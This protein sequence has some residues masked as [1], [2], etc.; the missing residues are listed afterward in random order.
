MRALVSDYTSEPETYNIDDEYLLCDNLLVAPIIVGKTEREVYLPEGN[1]RDYFTKNPV[2]DG[3][4]YSFYGVKAFELN[5]LDNDKVKMK[6]P[7]DIMGV[8]YPS[9]KNLK[10]GQFYAISDLS[11]AEMLQL[12]DLLKKRKNVTFRNIITETF[13]CCNSF[14]QCSDAKACLH[15]KDR[16][17]NGCYYR[18]NLE[19]GRIFY[20][21]NRNID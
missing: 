16:N 11:S 14:V 9:K 4:S 1:L 5:I 6:L 10:E 15:A 2:K 18:K 17:Y 13:A 8:L 12:V 19:S 3:Y 20:G 7:D 21:K